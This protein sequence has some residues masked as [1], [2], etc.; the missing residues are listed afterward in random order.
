MF[1][2][3]G[4]KKAVDFINYDQFLEFVG[5]LA[6]LAFNFC[7]RREQPP[8]VSFSGDDYS[9]HAKHLWAGN[10]A[11]LNPRAGESS[12]PPLSLPGFIDTDE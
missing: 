10:P 7:E 5:R 4:A 1:G 11:Q 12:K 9:E 6:L 3:N 8:R 2:V